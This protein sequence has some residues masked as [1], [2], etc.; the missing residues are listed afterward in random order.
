MKKLLLTAAILSTSINL[1]AVENATEPETTMITGV[2]YVDANDNCIYDVGEKILPGMALE[3]GDKKVYTDN[4][5]TYKL[6]IEPGSHEIELISNGD[7]AP[8][9]DETLKVDVSKTNRT[10]SNYNF[11]VNSVY[12]MKD[13]KSTSGYSAI[14]LEKTREKVCGEGAGSASIDHC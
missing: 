1:F 8:G 13:F 7:W 2:V 4:N 11:S 14:D 5:G 6:E 3:I 9:C 12:S 10:Y